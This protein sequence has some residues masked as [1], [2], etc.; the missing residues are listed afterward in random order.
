MRLKLKTSDVQGHGK[1]L[2]GEVDVLLE[3]MINV[4]YG[5]GDDKDN[6]TWLAK[7][8]ENLAPHRA[9]QSIYDEIKEEGRKYLKSKDDKED[10]DTDNDNKKDDRGVL[11]DDS[12][13]V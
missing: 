3:E 11:S 12:F 4:V 9:M 2:T 10:P 1:W 13:S 8:S 5:G 7:D 6:A